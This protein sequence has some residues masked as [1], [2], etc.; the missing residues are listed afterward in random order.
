MVNRQNYLKLFHAVI[1]H[2]HA[3]IFIT[4]SVIVSIYV[5]IPNFKTISR[6]TLIILLLLSKTRTMDLFLVAAYQ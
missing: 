4:K 3:N 5:Y 6:F 2:Y 1:Y